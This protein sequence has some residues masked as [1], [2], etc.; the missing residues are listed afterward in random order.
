MFG[1]V[2]HARALMLILIVW[3]KSSGYTL[4]NFAPIYYQIDHIRPYSRTAVLFKWESCVAYTDLPVFRTKRRDEKKNCE[5]FRFANICKIIIMYEILLWWHFIIIFGSFNWFDFI[6]EFVG[7]KSFRALCAAANECFSINVHAKLVA[8]V[9]NDT[10]A[11]DTLDLKWDEIKET[12]WKNKRQLAMRRHGARIMFITWHF[13]FRTWSGSFSYRRREREREKQKIHYFWIHKNV[14]CK[15][16]RKPIE[17]KWGGVR[18]TK[19]EW[20]LPTM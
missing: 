3:K 12:I 15:C 13:C 9:F 4:F 6:C 14:K 2:I 5:R 18:R 1:A 7:N 20:I 10:I 19:R 8:A 16:N 17:P 11:V